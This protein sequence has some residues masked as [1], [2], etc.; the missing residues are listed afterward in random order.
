MDYDDGSYIFLFIESTA[1]H[2]N[3][4]DQLNQ[5]LWR[6]GSAISIF[7]KFPRWSRRAV[8]LKNKWVM[9]CMDSVINKD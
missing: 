5:T 7:L 6:R 9:K 2:L 3:I 8:R 1:E 4:P